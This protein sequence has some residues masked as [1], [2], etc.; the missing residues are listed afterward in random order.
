MHT[1]FSPI[2]NIFAPWKLIAANDPKVPPPGTY[3]VHKG[4]VTYADLNA[5]FLKK[6]LRN[7]L[8]INADD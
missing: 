8:Y 4:R 5:L 3:G 1:P 2:I 7:Y 6:F